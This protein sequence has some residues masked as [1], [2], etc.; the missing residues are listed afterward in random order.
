MYTWK[1]HNETLCIAILN[2]Q[3]MFFILFYLQ[4]IEKGWSGP[5]W[6]LVPV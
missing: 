4:K 3:K 6:G 2:K 1:Y 5:V